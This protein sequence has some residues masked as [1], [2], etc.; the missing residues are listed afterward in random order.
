MDTPEGYDDW[1][2]R[3]KQR[4]KDIRRAFEARL[5]EENERA[6]LR[7][8]AANKERAID[9]QTQAQSELAT[10]DQWLNRRRREKDDEEARFL[11]ELNEAYA[12]WQVQG[13]R[14]E[15]EHRA[16]RKKHEGSSRCA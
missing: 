1:S 10:I 12:Q 16:Y 3:C 13:N 6:R 4:F 9:A 15:A 14:T 2:S 11:A 7:E 8:E 5:A